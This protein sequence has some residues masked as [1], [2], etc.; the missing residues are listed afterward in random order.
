M[1]G[2]RVA[3]LAAA[4]GVSPDT[5]RYYERSGLL[6]PPPRTA[7]GYRLYPAEAVD[8]LRFIQGCQRLG[9]RLKEIAELLAVRDT[10]VCPCEPAEELIRRHISELDA[11]LARLT[12]LR[13]DMVRTLTSL[14]DGQCPDV[15][16]GVW[17]PP[18]R[19]GG[20]S[21]A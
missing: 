7:A 19:E 15:A 3:E 21:C 20:E 5:V 16:P 4:A 13:T 11:E 12:A 9:L 10:G 1:Q 6:A 17:C 2:F 14:P 18:D 8:R